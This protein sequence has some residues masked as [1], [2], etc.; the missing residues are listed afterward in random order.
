MT[1]VLM[2]IELVVGILAISKVVQII[3]KI[4]KSIPEERGEIA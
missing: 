4:Y 1:T 3:L 2:I